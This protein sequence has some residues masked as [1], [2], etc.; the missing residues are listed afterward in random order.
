MKSSRTLLRAITL[1]LAASLIAFLGACSADDESTADSDFTPVTIQHAFGSTTIDAAPTRVVSLFADWTD[2]LAA[3]DIPM[4]ARFAESG[5]ENFPWTPANDA[6]V[7]PVADISQVSIDQIAKFN[8]DLILAGPGA[9]D[10]AAYKKFSAL[11]PTLPV[12]KQGTTVDTWESLAETAGKI[13]GKQDAATEL[14]SKTNAEIA[15]FKQQ[16]PAAAGKTFIFAQVTPQGFGAVNSTEDAS[17]GLLAQL[18]FTL[19]PGIAAL[20]EAGGATRARLSAERVDLLNSDLLVVYLPQ[21]DRNVVNQI[22]GW[23]NLKAVRN[24]TVVYIT[25]AEHG[26]FSVPSA[27]SVGFVIKTITPAVAKLT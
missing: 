21:G 6:E 4:V 16:H 13:F 26:A 11:A 25:D 5:H 2:T 3:L 19:E 18:G 12:L 9:A 22:P 10:E 27:P 15:A 7:V 8:P 1:A 17:A 24:G 14:I 23:N 20:H